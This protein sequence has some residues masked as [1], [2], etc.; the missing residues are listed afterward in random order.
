MMCC[1]EKDQDRRS[2]GI[3]HCPLKTTH[4]SYHI[5]LERSKESS[6]FFLMSSKGRL[7]LLC[8]KEAI[9]ST[10]LSMFI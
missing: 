6:D 5:G 2:D 9:Y 4:F 7:L 8:A 10:I 3:A 1:L